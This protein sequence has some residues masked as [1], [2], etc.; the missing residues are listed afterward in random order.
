MY[1]YGGLLLGF[2]A[3]ATATV[4]SRL[5]WEIYALSFMQTITCNARVV[6]S[7]YF[8]LQME[9]VQQ[10]QGKQILCTL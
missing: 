3:T 2:N 8:Y 5:W 6:V 4:I 1:A 9:Q 7:I 10:V